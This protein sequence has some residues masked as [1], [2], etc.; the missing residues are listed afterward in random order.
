MTPRDA[1]DAALEALLQMERRGAWSDGSLK[2]IAAQSGLEARDA[3][4][5]TRLTYGVVQNRTLLD[6][7]IDHWCTQKAARLEPV[8]TCLLRLGIYQILFMDKVPDRAAV[9][10]TVELAKRRGKTR[11][12]GMI[13]AV[14]RKCASSKN[15]LPPLPQNSF[16]SKAA[17]QYSHPRW[18]VERLTALAGEQEAEAFLRLDNEPVPT[19][20]QANP[21]K[22]T[23]AELENELRSDGV[24]LVPHPWLEGCFEVTGTGDLER[25]SAFASG[26][27]T[28]QDA[29]ARLAAIAAGP[30]PGDRVLDVCAAPGGKS[31][32]MAM[33]MENRGDI[34]SC[35]IHPHKIDLI[36]AGAERLGFQN[37]EP[38]LRDASVFNPEWEKGMDTVIADV[39]CSGLGIIRK[40]PDIRYKDL[41]ETEA[42]PGL[43]LQILK[44]VSR[45]VRP[46]GVLMYSTCTV[47]PRE[48]EQVV[49]AFLADNPDFSPEKLAL[50]EVF[51]RNETGMLT[52]IPG[53]Y[54]TDGFFICRLRRKQ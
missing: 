51:P 26:R 32:A 31:F 30:K 15:T 46:G 2:R 11:A 23:P 8:V 20:I 43:Q 21:L 37:V 10:E 24:R 1:R 48:N 52:L 18:L 42:L 45:Y 3:A 49:S 34:L 6:Y 54:D 47:L 19:V 27:C 4:L 33:Q 17:V 22:T 13:N 53:E 5:C 35:D 16:V 44:N 12:A 25:L 36:R 14:L 28:V 50:P 39:P 41:K 7:Y 9:H 38:M 29:A 40:K